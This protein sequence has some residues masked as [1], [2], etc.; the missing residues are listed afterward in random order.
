MTCPVRAKLVVKQMRRGRLL[1]RSCRH[2]QL[3]DGPYRPSGR[4]AYPS[5]TPPTIMSPTRG[6]PRSSTEIRL[7]TRAHTTNPNDQAHAPP[8]LQPFTHSNQNPGTCVGMHAQIRRG[9]C[10]RRGTPRVSA[11]PSRS[12]C[13]LPTIWRPRKQRARLRSRAPR[14]D[15]P[16][17][18]RPIRSGACVRQGQGRSS[19]RPPTRTAPRWPRRGGLPVHAALLRRPCRRRPVRWCRPSRVWRL[20]HS[21]EAR[22]SRSVAQRSSRPR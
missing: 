1:A 8:A 11:R 9:G 2:D 7:S 22:T 16:G 19:P 14:A 18:M 6:T 3:V 17:W 12:T 21:P 5:G 13:L 10:M 20:Q 15:V 4:N